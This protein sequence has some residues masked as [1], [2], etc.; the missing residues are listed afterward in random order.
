[1]AAEGSRHGGQSWT[2]ELLAQNEAGEGAEDEAPKTLSEE[3]LYPTIERRLRSAYYQMVSS[4]LA[5]W[6]FLPLGIS[7]SV[8]GLAWN[9]LFYSW[10]SWLD[11]LVFL[12]TTE[13]RSATRLPS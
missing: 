11:V 7:C 12:L 1:M 10:P 13:C 4:L 5:L 3:I 9:F 2:E 6:D 8:V